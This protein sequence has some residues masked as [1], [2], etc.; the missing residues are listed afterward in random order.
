MLFL[1]SLD[2]S[3]LYCL[4]LFSHEYTYLFFSGHLSVPFWDGKRLLFKVYCYYSFFQHLQTWFMALQHSRFFCFF[5]LTLATR[6]MC[7]PV[8]FSPMRLKKFSSVLICSS[9]L[10]SLHILLGLPLKLVLNNLSAMTP[11]QLIISGI[12]YF[13]SVG[14]NCSLCSQRVAFVSLY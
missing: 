9:S 5:F 8:S 10:F 14:V 6:I 2:L 1:F 7:A 13:H 4:L 3:S 12:R 11:S